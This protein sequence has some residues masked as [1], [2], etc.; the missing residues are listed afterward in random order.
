MI[1]YCYGDGL[2]NWVNLTLINNQSYQM[3]A[4]VELIQKLFN[5]TAEFILEMKYAPPLQSSL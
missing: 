2:N 5:R 1:E 4:E 3:S